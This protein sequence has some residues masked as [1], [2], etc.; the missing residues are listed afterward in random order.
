MLE[1]RVSK[2]VI[3]FSC[4]VNLV[5]HARANKEEEEEGGKKK[6]TLEEKDREKEREGE[7]E[8]MSVT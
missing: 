6:K 3:D 5:G 8:E 4:P 2:Q 7:E 1:R